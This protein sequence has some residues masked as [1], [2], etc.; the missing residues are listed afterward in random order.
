M[1]GEVWLLVLVRWWRLLV[2]GMVP[3]GLELVLAPSTRETAEI[4]L[5]QKTEDVMVHILL[6]RLERT[7]LELW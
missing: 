1:A 4:W 2:L 5:V 7:G 3:R 6:L